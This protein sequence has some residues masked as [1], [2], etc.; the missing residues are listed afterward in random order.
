MDARL[1]DFN[2]LLRFRVV[3]GSPIDRFRGFV[4]DRPNELNEWTYQR[5][6]GAQ[7]LDLVA[8]Q[9]QVGQAGTFLRQRVQTPR[10]GVIA[11][12]QLK[13]RKRIIRRAERRKQHTDSNNYS[14]HSCQI[15]PHLSTL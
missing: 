15:F 8:T 13:H 12:L 5:L 6:D 14:A 4:S 2:L 9:V 10:D 11:H 1:P 3:S 7:I